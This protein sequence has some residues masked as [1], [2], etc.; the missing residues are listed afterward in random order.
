MAHQVVKTKTE[1]R[2]VLLAN[3]SIVK[4]NLNEVAEHIALNPADVNWIN[5]SIQVIE[6][7]EE[8]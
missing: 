7:I 4:L 1:I 8:V 3:M 6:E 5:L 2:Y